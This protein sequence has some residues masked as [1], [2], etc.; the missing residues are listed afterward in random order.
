MKPGKTFRATLDRGKNNLNWVIVRIPFDAAK[1][2]GSRGQIKVKGDIN[3]FEFRTSLFPDGDGRHVMLVN[4]RMQNAAEVTVGMEAKFRLEPDTAPRV[5][6]VPAEFEGFLREDPGLRRWFGALSY[7]TRRYIGDWILEVKS[8]EA[9]VRR[10]TQLAERLIATM[11]AER[12]LPPLIKRAFA[13][14]PIAE[15]GWVRMP[16]SH[17]R[18]HLM[19][20]FYYRDP[21]SRA[22]R[23][24]KTLEECRKFA[25][26]D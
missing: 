26:K 20:I 9:R 8:P 11:E 6:Q 14:D 22:R 24:A 19:A 7:S 13:N 1:L 10:A 2:W 12:E 17:R 15:Q 16:A 18:R 5:A 25:R 3:G 21:R 23:I 4:R